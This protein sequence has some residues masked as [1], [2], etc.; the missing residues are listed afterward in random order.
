M[1]ARR[2]DCQFLSN[3][4]KTHR[5]TVALDAGEVAAARAH[6]CPEIAAQA[7]ALGRAYKLAPPGWR[8]VAH[9]VTPAGA[10]N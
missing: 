9:G 10:I 4:G 7:Y 2:W 6:E 3:D 1:I 8:H 5:L